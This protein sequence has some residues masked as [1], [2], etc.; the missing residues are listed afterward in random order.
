MINIV[1]F[2]S[3]SINS[4]AEVAPQMGDYMQGLI[5][6]LPVLIASLV[7]LFIL[8]IVVTYFAYFPVKKYIKERKQHVAGNIEE[9]EKMNKQSHE[10]LAKANNKLSNSKTEGRKIIQQYTERAN[11]EASDIVKQAQDQSSNII[12]QATARIKQDEKQMRANLNK[13]ISEI[14][15]AATE[16]LLKENMSTDSN[17]K[18]VDEFISELNK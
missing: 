5:P 6:S 1:P 18:L 4:M 8:T 13:E 15:I 9:A 10:T 2:I 11:A 14:A 3:E 7:S 16:K 17:K 12:E